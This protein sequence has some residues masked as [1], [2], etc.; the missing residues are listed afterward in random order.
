MK[1]VCLVTAFVPLPVSHLTE[2]QYKDL[3]AKLKRAASAHTV[4][5]F[6]EDQLE[7]CWLHQVVPD[8]LKYPPAAPVPGDRF[9]TPEINVMSHV[10]QHNR[11]TWAIR[12]EQLHPDADVF[13]WA[14]YGVIKQG[15][16]TARPVMEPMISKFLDKVAV[17]DGDDIPYPGIDRYAKIDPF[18]NNW[19]FCG[20][21]H[22]WPKRYLRAIDIAYKAELLEFIGKHQKVP[23]DLAIWPAVQDNHQYLPFRFYQA[24]YDYTQFTEFPDA[25]SKG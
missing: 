6:E 1:K 22:I 2:S 11:T 8:I 15:G 4:A 25:S 3:G 13:V 17:Y 18:G 23:L 16:H 21:L 24:E 19:R 14:D 12:A 20:S 10:I 7:Q 5:S 9:A